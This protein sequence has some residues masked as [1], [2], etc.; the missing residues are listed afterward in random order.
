MIK[1]Y[2]ESNAHAEHV[3]TFVDEETY[4]ICLPALEKDAKKNGMT[5]TEGEEE[6]EVKEFFSVLRVHR[7][8]LKG[9]DYDKAGELSDKDME[10]IASRIGDGIMES[11]AYWSSVDSVIDRLK[12]EDEKSK[13]CK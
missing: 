9:R 3:A 2:F 11:G 13:H 8:D 7:D 12:D 4:N 5:V 1:V 6:E 10:G